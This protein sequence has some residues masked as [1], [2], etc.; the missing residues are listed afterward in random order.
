MAGGAVLQQ[1]R[2]VGRALAHALGV[3]GHLE[4]HD[5]EVGPFATLNA[6][7]L[8]RGG[9]DGR[10]APIVV[11]L[12]V[13]GRE[14]ASRHGET[15]EHQNH[16]VPEYVEGEDAGDAAHLIAPAPDS[17]NHEANDRNQDED[18]RAEEDK[19]RHGLFR[20]EVV[21]STL[22]Y[23]VP[24]HKPGSHI[25]KMNRLTVLFTLGLLAGC[26]EKPR[27]PARTAADSVGSAT[28]S[29][30][31]VTPLPA[32]PSPF[33]ADRDTAP[34]AQAIGSAAP[35]IPSCGSRV[36]SIT[37]DSIG[38]FRPGMRLADL[39]RRCPRLMYGWVMISDGYAVPTVAARVGG[40][41]VTA[42][43]NDSSAGA[44]LNR[45]ELVGRGPRTAEGVGVG[46]T[47]A[48]LERRYGAPQASESDCLLQVWFD[49][50]PGLGFR[51]A[52]PT[53]RECGA[54]S[55]PPLPP[56]VKVVA[57]ILIAQ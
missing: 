50:R 13:A 52:H 9:V 6:L 35:V 31:V 12:A 20:Y 34:L 55:E 44:V 41:T 49:A 56:E 51:M 7:R 32:V 26:G 47:L 43:A 10:H 16:G 1:G 8:A 53:G 36:P 5:P 25:V 3:T 54:I 40:A 57:V 18:D 28:P 2:G 19:G 24:T 27:P 38:P 48:E 14:R 30:P 45:I 11:A 15:H 46:S 17:G 4:P 33:P 37:T 23:K 21:Q 39:V 42:Y 29:T 22:H